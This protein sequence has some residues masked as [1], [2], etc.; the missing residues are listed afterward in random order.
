NDAL[1]HRMLV[2]WNDT[3]VDNGPE[4]NVLQVIDR[5]F[6][7]R[8]DAIVASEVVDPATTTRR[9]AQRSVRALDRQSRRTA[10]GLLAAG[11]QADDPVILLA[12]RDL[13][14]WVSMLGILRAGAA[15]L[16]IAPDLPP[17][18]IA[19]VIEESG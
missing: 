7:E 9:A 6:R 19:Q 17:Q 3:A 14:F 2:E 12:K 13:P 5:I 10:L 1:A 15:Y 11:V 4:H 8:P 18:R 16:P